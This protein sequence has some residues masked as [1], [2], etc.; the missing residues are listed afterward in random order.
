[1]YHNQSS[2]SQDLCLS[3]FITEESDYNRKNQILDKM[4][5]Y[6]DR[7]QLLN[8]TLQQSQP[9]SPQSS[10]SFPD[11]PQTAS[12]APTPTSQP[13]PQPTVQAPYSSFSP[14]TQNNQPQASPYE[15][16]HNSVVAPYSS[17]SSNIRAPYDSY[18]NTTSPP[19]YESAVTQPPPYSAPPPTEAW[20]DSFSNSPSSHGNFGSFSPP[21]EA[22]VYSQPPDMSRFGVSPNSSPSGSFTNPPQPQISPPSSFQGQMGSPQGSFNQNTSPYGSGGPS[23]NSPSAY[24]SGGSTFVPPQRPPPSPSGSFTNPPQPQTSPP[25]SFQ[26]Q[27]GS[28]QGSFNQNAPTYGSGPSF[29]SSAPQPSYGNT[30]LQVPKS[31]P[32]PQP[33]SG[34]KYHPFILH[35][36]KEHP[37]SVPNIQIALLIAEEAKKED[38]SRQY[39]NA[40]DLYTESLERFLV[41]YKSKYSILYFN[42]HE[43]VY[44][45]LWIIRRK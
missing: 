9:S 12:P 45:Y 18:S 24:G 29:N 1:M 22:P 26:G 16:Q 40:L 39:Q 3:F 38:R 28:P 2:H 43:K 34:P 14:M 20:G 41:V 25:S 32:A 19:S 15:N 30:N 35:I 5:E 36:N 8:T 44:L 11:T 13:T 10:F 6:N 7:M 27:M 37:R 42:H 33:S 21:S 17:S 23:F 4:K 31:S